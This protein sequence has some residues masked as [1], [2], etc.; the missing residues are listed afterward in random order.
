[1]SK[2]RPEEKKHPRFSRV[3]SRLAATPAGADFDPNPPKTLCF[4]VLFSK[5]ASRGAPA[6]GTGGKNTSHFPV[7]A[8]EKKHSPLFGPSVFSS[9][10]RKHAHLVSKSQ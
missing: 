3:A 6:L 10:E 5:Y 8:E 7:G 1:M 2:I 4:L 9:G